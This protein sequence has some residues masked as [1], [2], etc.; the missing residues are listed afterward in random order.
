MLKH[1]TSYCFCSFGVSVVL[2][3]WWRNTASVSLEA[4]GLLGTVNTC[5]L[6]LYTTYQHILLLL[7]CLSTPHCPLQNNHI[8]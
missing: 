6:L 1:A 5:L 2:V 7:T 3:E 4:E 8:S